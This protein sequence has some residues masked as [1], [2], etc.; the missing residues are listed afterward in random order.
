MAAMTMTIDVWRVANDENPRIGQRVVTQWRYGGE[1]WFDVML[2]DGS[3]YLAWSDDNKA[4]CLKMDCVTYW[5]DIPN[6]PAK[7]EN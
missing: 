2:F 7:E 3:D 4:Y 6:G 5:T 1:R